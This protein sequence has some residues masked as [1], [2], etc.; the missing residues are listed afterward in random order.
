MLEC[1]YLTGVLAVVLEELLDLVAGLSIWDLDI[2][3]GGSI[4]VHE[5][6]ETIISDVELVDVLAHA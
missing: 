5:G 4:I 3:L 1:S 2:V 6:E